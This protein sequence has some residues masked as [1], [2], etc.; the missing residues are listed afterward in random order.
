MY[1]SISR[2]VVRSGYHQWSGSGTECLFSTPSTSTE[3]IHHY[4][5]L[6]PG[7]R[8]FYCWFFLLVF[9]GLTDSGAH[10]LLHPA[11]FVSR[12]F[13]ARAA[14]VRQKNLSALT[15]HGEA[16]ESRTVQH[17]RACLGGLRLHQTN[18]GAA[19][20]PICS[21]TVE[22]DSPFGVEEMCLAKTTTPAP[23]NE[24]LN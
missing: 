5:H 13:R 15:R 16:T 19:T 18:S 12:P 14:Y 17:F 8:P 2:L 20:P 24:D 10:H 23:K 7:F 9:F 11:P 4:H 21:S 3:P 6:A 1:F 22:L